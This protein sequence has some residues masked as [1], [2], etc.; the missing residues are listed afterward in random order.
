MV[1]TDTIASGTTCVVVDESKGIQV[2]AGAVY[3]AS[4][5]SGT[6]DEDMNTM[7]NGGVHR[8]QCQEE[9]GVEYGSRSYA[10]SDYY[11]MDG[12]CRAVWYAPETTPME[13]E[14][15][16]FGDTDEMTIAYKNE[17]GVLQV[18]LDGVKRGEVNAAATTGE[19]HLSEDLATPVDVVERE[20][21]LATDGF[22]RA[23]ESPEF[24]GSHGSRVSQ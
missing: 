10:T 3:D 16:A 9:E 17:R 12:G 5:L 24:G 6:S 20:S 8:E 4:V 13:T 1:G 2:Y 14:S 22:P 18:Y 23:W 21:L 7:E 15:V 11:P 19:E